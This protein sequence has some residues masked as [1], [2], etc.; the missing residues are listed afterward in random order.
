MNGRSREVTKI[1]TAN[2]A[3]AVGQLLLGE[4]KDW[5]EFLQAD[6][7]DLES[8]PRRNLKAGF[9][10]VRRRL[11]SEIKGFCG[12]NFSNITSAVLSDLY[13]DIKSRRGLEL[14]LDEFEQKYSAFE[15][16]VLRGQPQHATVVISLWGLQF[17][18]PESYLAED[19]KEALSQARTGEADLKEYSGMSHRELE[20][21]REEIARL[22]RRQQ[23]AT[24][25]C[26]L[27]CFNLVEAYFNGIAWEFA[28]R[29]GRMN[30]LSNKKRQLILDSGHTS[31][32]D[33]IIKYPKIIKDGPLWDENQE[34]VK[35]FLNEIKPFRDSVV[36]AS[37]FSAPEKFG[38]IDKLQTLYRLD[39]TVAE[40]AVHL[41]T[42]IIT[43]THRHLN[44]GAIPRPP[45]LED[46]RK[47][48]SESSSDESK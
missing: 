43:L 3:S 34:P 48:V 13:E 31:I 23:F 35:S 44:G 32:R 8:L 40:R 37:P 4:I 15:P 24:R 27:S 6:S 20:K 10:D 30:E 12:R 47:A 19:V 7:I 33:K 22:T 26:L 16:R 28:R 5:A 14:P 42:E 39:I 2:R 9:S 1:R 17:K 41:T 25:T 18:Y 29:T 21:K 11:S 46:L 36:H 45:W 38:G